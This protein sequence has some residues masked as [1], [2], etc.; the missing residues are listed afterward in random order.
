MSLLMLQGVLRMTPDLWT[1]DPVD[2]SQR[3]ARY[4][5]AA[6]K[7]KAI[8]DLVNSDVESNEDLITKVR[9]VLEE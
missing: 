2:I 6:D 4:V 3:H 9:S 1:G 7:L 5:D 8:S